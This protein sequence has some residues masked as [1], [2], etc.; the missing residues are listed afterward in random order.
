MLVATGVALLAIVALFGCGRGPAMCPRIITGDPTPPAQSHC[1]PPRS[2]QPLGVVAMRVVLGPDA[3]YISGA[4]WAD[5]LGTSTRSEGEARAEARAHALKRMSDDCI[6]RGF[7]GI[8]DSSVGTSRCVR[9]EDVPVAVPLLGGVVLRAVLGDGEAYWRCD[10]SAMADCFR[11]Q[12]FS[13][14]PL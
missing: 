4:S 2:L 3:E 14:D 8:Y 9:H 12:K 6:S 7:D 5:G 11:G 10:V 1:T 13:E